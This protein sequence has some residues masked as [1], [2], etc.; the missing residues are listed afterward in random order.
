MI[1]LFFVCKLY[2]TDTVNVVDVPEI[3]VEGD[4]ELIV[5]LSTAA[6]ESDPPPLPHPDA[7]K[8][9]INIAAVQN[10]VRSF[11]LSLP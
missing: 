4:M 10:I 2:E 5:M 6:G 7:K 8:T 1:P 11:M 9:T 3:T